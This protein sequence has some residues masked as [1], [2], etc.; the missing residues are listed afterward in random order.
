VRV[1]AYSQLVLVLAVLLVAAK[2]R[3][4]Q[5]HFDNLSRGE[6]TVRIRELDRQLSW[7]RA[8]QAW[9]MAQ[10]YL[11]A[12]DARTDGVDDELEDIFLVRNFVD[13]EKVLVGELKRIRLVT[14]PCFRVVD[15]VG[16]DVQ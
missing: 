1:A 16:V 9:T 6:M 12:V 3:Q 13:G 15:W 4:G 8:A 2:E 5:R 10:S 11:V 7:Q 14:T